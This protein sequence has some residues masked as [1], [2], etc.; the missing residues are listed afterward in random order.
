M[1]RELPTYL[2]EGT[3]FIVDVSKLE[4]REKSNPSNVISFSEMRHLGDR[5]QFTYSL[6]DKNTPSFFNGGT[7]NITVSVP[8]LVSLDPIGMAVRYGDGKR[9]IEGKSD[10]DLM[11]DQEALKHRLMGFL[12][13]IDIAG[14][15]FYVD[16]RMD[17][18]RP[19]DDFLSNGVSFRDIDHCY[20]D[21]RHVYT[22]PYNPKTHEFQDIDGDT[23]TAIPK[24]L[25]AVEIPHEHFMDPVGLNRK[26]GLD[27]K[28][29]L[30][31]VGVRTHFQAKIIDWKSL[32]IEAI[33]QKNL[34]Q[35]KDAS[36]NPKQ[37]TV[38]AKRQ[39][40]GRHI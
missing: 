24:E 21:Q 3:E 23:L 19:K 36:N 12:P 13:T 28:A 29:D 15:T 39:R 30:K 32:G 20:D 10:L 35:D 16:L 17:R 6:H 1:K 27:E 11:V 7:D 31:F 40:R 37:K 14:H 2:I 5:Y 8:S 4:L 34:S 33:I 38:Q 26:M 22:F 25:L 9:G 18:L